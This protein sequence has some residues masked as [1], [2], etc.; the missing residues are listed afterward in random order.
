M[1]Y[2]E[3]GVAEQRAAAPP[4]SFPMGVAGKSFSA[5]RRPLFW[6]L[7]MPSPPGPFDFTAPNTAL[8]LTNL[9]LVHEFTTRN[10][11]ST[12]EDSLIQLCITAASVELLWRTGR[13][14]EGQVPTN[15]PFVAPVAYDETYDGN[16]SA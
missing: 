1:V 9:A 2:R 4:I 7:Q 8:D 15:S 12:K 16:A 10:T 6:I 14:P 11:T 5:L 3:T 13:G